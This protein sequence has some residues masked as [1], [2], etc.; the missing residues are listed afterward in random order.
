MTFATALKRTMFEF[1][2]TGVELSRRSGVSKNTISAFRQGSQS[3]T[4]E[5]LEK[6][7][8]AMPEEARKYFFS[9]L[10]HGEYS[11]KTEDLSLA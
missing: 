3:L 9:E 11:E 8:G 6:L 4:V 5:N 2:L 10:E 7:L 1:G